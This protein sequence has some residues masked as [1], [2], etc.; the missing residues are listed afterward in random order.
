MFPAP[1]KYPK[2]P[3]WRDEPE[4]LKL[5]TRWFDE[6]E[7]SEVMAIA[8]ADDGGPVAI[9]RRRDLRDLAR[10]L[11]S[12]EEINRHDGMHFA[13][14]VEELIEKQ[15]KRKRGRPP[16]PKEE[17]RSVSILPDAKA[18]CLAVIDFLR[19][20][21]P[22]ESAGVIRDRAIL[23]TVEKMA[24]YEVGGINPLTENKLRNYMAR[25]K[26]DPRVL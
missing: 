15:Q 5:V 23:W 21:Y 17:R 25:S 18:L 7:Y 9:P 24:T 6:H 16:K 19:L 12:G 13:G 3:K 4:V 1:V 10:M 11:R 2:P 26:R 8:A 14:L 22:K 20:N